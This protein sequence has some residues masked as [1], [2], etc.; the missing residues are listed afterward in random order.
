MSALHL[1]VIAPFLQG[2][3]MGE[4]INHIRRTCAA[5]DY[6]FTLIR[7]NSLGEFSL[8]LGVSEFD[9]VITI[10]NAASPK[11]VEYLQNRA[12]PVVAIAHD[13]FPLDVPIITSNNALGMDL[14]FNYLLE[15]NHKRITF[16]GDLSQYDIRKRFERFCELLDTHGLHLTDKSLI[17]VSD[18][19][20][21]GGR[22]AAARFTG[23]LGHAD[24]VVC[25][26]G[27]TGMGFVKQ[28]NSMGINIPEKLDVISFDDVAFMRL[29]TPNMP[30]IDQNLDQVA[31][32]ALEALESLITQS[33]LTS[34]T[35]Y[36]DPTLVTATPKEHDSAWQN[37][38]HELDGLNN[39][40]YVDSLVNNSFE[41]THK[42]LD[43][44]LDKLMSLSPM[45]QQHMHLACLAELKKDKF[46]RTR[47]KINKVF[48]AS[49]EEVALVDDDSH[50]VPIE[51]YPGK[52]FKEKYGNNHPTVV[53]FPI[54]VDANLWGFISVFGDPNR[55]NYPTSFAGFT[56]YMDTITHAYSLMLSNKQ[57]EAEPEIEETTNTEVPDIL[58]P[59]LKW[60]LETGGVVW[61]EKALEKLGFTTDLEKSIYRN[62][63]V[64]DRVH[65]EDEHGLRKEITLSLTHLDKMN[66]LVRLKIAQGGFAQF[67]IEGEVVHKKDDRAVIYRC[68]ISQIN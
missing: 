14:A 50:L 64:F 51:S 6:R 23:H 11:M 37:R 67:R 65:P 21:T 13:Y 68:I 9:G 58:T 30:R 47:L 34:H 66:T 56:G 55:A 59:C 29:L 33:P 46:N 48:E 15:R 3:Y 7:T 10:R 63:E 26:A 12:I 2:G 35:L 54:F 20:F 57:H 61:N 62:M 5:R 40:N 53:H 45:F 49:T 19:L 16:V 28:L 25:G 31:A 22:E 1:C 39:L 41:L 44:N 38:I 36:V 17:C 24:A 4:I 18:S 8:N 60:D 52:A 43:S 27:H 32:R 42:I